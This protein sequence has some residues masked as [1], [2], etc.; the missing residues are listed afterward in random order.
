MERTT[1]LFSELDLP[2]VDIHQR[3]IFQFQP[4]NAPRFHYINSFATYIKSDIAPVAFQRI[5]AH[6]R[7]RYSDYSPIYTDGSKRTDYVVCGVA[8]EDNARVLLDTKPRGYYRQ[9]AS[10]NLIV[11]SATTELPL[12]VRPRDMK[13]VI[14][15]R[16]KNAWQESW[17]LQTNNKLH[18]VKPVI[19]ALPV[20][21]MRRTDV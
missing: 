1:L 18:C 10:G 15:H 3:N 7:S 11:Q 4:W 14:Q 13:R 6:H 16:I 17:N 5:F 9:R 20:M 21:P 19:G 8:T 2:D 12:T